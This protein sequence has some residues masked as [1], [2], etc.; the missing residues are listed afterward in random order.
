MP[1]WKQLPSCATLSL[2]LLGSLAGHAQSSTV[3]ISSP[4]H[5]IILHFAVRPDKGLSSGDG[6][7]VYSI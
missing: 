4:D 2:I 6:Q 7:L 5:R 1:Q 3:E